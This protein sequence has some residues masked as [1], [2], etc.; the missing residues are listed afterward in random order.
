MLHLDSPTTTPVI[1]SSPKKTTKSSKNSPDS[2]SKSDSDSLS[3]SISADVSEQNTAAD[4]I[5]SLGPSTFPTTGPF[6]YTSYQF[7]SSSSPSLEPTAYHPPIV[8]RWWH[9]MR[10]TQSSFVES[11]SSPSLPISIDS[12]SIVVSPTDGDKPVLTNKPAIAQ[13]KAQLADDD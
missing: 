7:S 5:I 9:T 13:T 3:D 12:A 6:A 4:K 1:N 8:F 2:E 10:P 11:I